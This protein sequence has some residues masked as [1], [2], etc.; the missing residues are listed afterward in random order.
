MLMAKAGLLSAMNQP[1]EN[2]E[3]STVGAEAIQLAQPATSLA[4]EQGIGHA[5]RQARGEEQG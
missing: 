3:L 1:M 5:P 2:A 4:A